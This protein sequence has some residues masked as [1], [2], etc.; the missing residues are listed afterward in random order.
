MGN[1]WYLWGQAQSF[2]LKN[3]KHS[4]NTSQQK[5]MKD[6]ETNE[7]QLI[8]VKTTEWVGAMNSVNC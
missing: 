1:L 3:W 8:D 2:K 7:K 6:E 5:W 4:K